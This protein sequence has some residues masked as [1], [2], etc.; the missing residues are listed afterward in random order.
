MRR[1]EFIAG[2]G[3]AV[4]TWPITAR[5]QQDGRVRRVGIIFGG[6]GPNDPELQARVAALKQ[7]MQDQGWIEGRNVI[8]DLSIGGGDADRLQAQVNELIGKSPDVIASNS[9]AAMRALTGKTQTIPIVSLNVT[10]LVAAGVI[11]SLARPG[12]NVTGFTSFEPSI[13]GKWLEL[14]N[15]VAPAT[16]RIAVVFDPANAGFWRA[17]EKAATGKKTIALS[18][19]TRS[20]LEREI[21]QFAR[22]PG[23]ALVFLPSTTSTAHRDLIIRLS[24]QHKLPTIFGFPYFAKEGGLLSYGID[25]VDNFR[26]AASY[27]DRILRGAKPSDLPIQQPIKFQLVINMKTAKAL[28]LTVPPKLLFTADEVIE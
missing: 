21:G 24:A 8:Y 27:V 19:T 13:V 18:V 16:Q 4:V 1:R 26:R 14:L 12:G 23:G 5:A 20:D 7:G 15:E 11:P 9:S 2:L 10:D 25:V 3:G 17:A 22:E 28:G 6:F